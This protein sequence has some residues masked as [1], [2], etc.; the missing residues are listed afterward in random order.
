MSTTETQTIETTVGCIAATLARL[1]IPDDR[2]LTV[3]LEPDDWLTKARR[4]SRKLVT[5]A[6]FS[7]DDLDRLIEEARA[8]VQPK[9]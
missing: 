1:G 6:G 4:E 2:F 8:E 9:P 5:A 3:V 7:D